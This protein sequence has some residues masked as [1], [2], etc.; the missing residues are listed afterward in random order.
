[1]RHRNV[2]PFLCSS[3]FIVGMPASAAFGL[4]PHSAAAAQACF[5]PEMLHHRL[6]R[7]HLSELCGEGGAGGG[8]S[9]SQSGLGD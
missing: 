5:I 3:P 8:G 7:V 1:V 2:A 6:F 4:Y 9:L